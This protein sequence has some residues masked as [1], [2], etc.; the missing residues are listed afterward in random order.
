MLRTG[1]G[2]AFSFES[3]PPDNWVLR[4]ADIEL[5]TLNISFPEIAFRVQ[6]GT[7]YQTT[8]T[9]PSPAE[10][11]EA[12]CKGGS[13][14]KSIIVHGTVS[15]STLGLPFP[16]ARVAAIWM[17]ETAG[18]NPAAGARVAREKEVIA[19]G[20][21]KFAFCDLKPNTQL[22]VGAAAGDL[23]SQSV[24]PLRLLEGGIYM[25]NLRLAPARK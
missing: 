18:D 2:G 10:G 15:D 25:V 11:R 23:H 8:I 3:L 6:A 7:S 9:M 21:G 14:P 19:D 13:D 22:T 17:E 12:L 24:S 20:R 16:R 1:A 5:D 4:V